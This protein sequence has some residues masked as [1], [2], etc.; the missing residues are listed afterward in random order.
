MDEQTINTQINETNETTE[1][2]QGA[3]PFQEYI[4][5]INDLKANSVSKEKYE[6]LE[7]EKKGLIEALKNGGQVNVVEPKEEVNIDELRKDLYGNPEKQMTNLEYISK[8]LKLRNALIEKG[9]PDPFMPNGHEYQF[10]Q[11]DQD[12]ANYVAQVYQECI[13][14][15]QGNDQLFTQEL[16]RRTKDDSPLSNFAR[17]RR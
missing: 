13:D 11:R 16:M 3:N 5:T 17:N 10:D 12:K 8:T 7:K 15:A 14:Y 1:Q 2:G 6:Q 4:D 9:E